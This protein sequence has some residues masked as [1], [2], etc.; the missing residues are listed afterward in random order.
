M[1]KST[2]ILLALCFSSLAFS[3]AFDSGESSYFIENNGQLT[4]LDGQAAD[5]VFFYA[6][7]NGLL[8][9]VKSHGFSYI[10]YQL[11][12]DKEKKDKFGKDISE[13]KSRVIYQAQ[14][15]DVDFGIPGLSNK[16]RLIIKGEHP[17]GERIVGVNTYYLGND[18]EIET[19]SYQKVRIPDVYKGIDVVCEIRDGKFKYS[20]ELNGVYLN[21]PDAIEMTYTGADELALDDEG[22]LVVGTELGSLKE[23][24]PIS[25]GK[26]GEELESTFLL[27][28]NVVRFQLP[29]LDDYQGV[30]IDPVLDWS[31]YAS[32]T[33][34]FSLF[35][36]VVID[37]VR[38]VYAAGRSDGPKYPTTVGAIQDTL[39]GFPMDAIIA[40]YTH[41]GKRR[42]ATYYGGNNIDVAYNLEVDNEQNVVVVGHSTST[43]FRTTTNAYQ[44]TNSGA[45]D[46]FVLKIDSAGKLVSSTLFGGTYDE[47][48]DGIAIDTAGS[49]IISG[50]TFSSDIPVSNGAFQTSTA[51]TS[52]T[53]NDA[54]LA[55]FDKSGKLSWSTYMGGSGIEDR[56][57]CVTVDEAG[58]IYGAGW[59]SST[60]FPVSNGAQQGTYAGNVDGFVFKFTASGGR[61]WATYNGGTDTDWSEDIALDDNDDVYCA[62][63]TYSTNYPVT[64][65][66]IQAFLAGNEDT[67]A[68]KYRSNGRL[69]WSTYVGGTLPDRSYGI[70]ADQTGG[71]Y[72]AGYTISANFPTLRAYQSIKGSQVDGFIYKLNAA[73]GS[74]LYSSLFGGNN[75]DVIYG[76]DMDHQGKLMYA[77]FTYSTNLPTRNA[78]QSSCTVCGNVGGAFVGSLCEELGNNSISGGNS[79]CSAIPISTKLSGSLPYGGNFEYFWETST[80]TTNWLLITK[81][82]GQDYTTPKL[83]DTTYFRRI[84]T[85]ACGADTS[86]V[87][88]LTVSRTPSGGQLKKGTLFNGTYSS[89][90]VDTVCAG[91]TIS[92]AITPPANYSNQEY[93]SKW[94]I[95]VLTTSGNGSISDTS[96]VKPV[97]Q[98]YT[99]LLSANSGFE[100]ELVTITFLVRDV[101]SGCDTTL[102]RQFYVNQ[103]LKADFLAFSACQYQKIPFTD[104][105]STIEG[106][107]TGWQWEFGDGGTSNVQNPDHA[108]S[109]DGTFD[110]KLTAFGDS[111]CPST[112]SKSLTV[113]SAPDAGFDASDF[114]FKDTVKFSDTS[115]FS[116]PVSHSWSFGNGFRSSLQNPTHIYKKEG[117]FDVQLIVSNINC[118]DTA[119]KTITIR[120]TPEA[121]FDIKDICENATPVIKEGSTISSGSIVSYQWDV[122]G[123]LYNVQSP[124]LPSFAMA[125]SYDAELTVES[126][127]GCKDAKS[128]AFS[129]YANP[130]AAFSAVSVCQGEAISLT[131]ESTISQGRITQNRWTLGDGNRSFQ[132]DPV[133]TYAQAGDYTVKLETESDEGCKDSIEKQVQIKALPAATFTRSEVSNLT[134]DFTADESSATSYSWNFGDGET[135]TG[136]SVQHEYATAGTYDVRLTVV[137]DD[138]EGAET[139]ELVVKD[140]HVNTVNGSEVSFYPNPVE[141]TLHIQ[142]PSANENVEI[143]ILDIN[144]RVVLRLNALSGNDGLI[145]LDIQAA[146][147]TNGVF[148][149]QGAS[150]SDMVRAK[151]TKS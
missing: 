94:E 58:N 11:Q 144:G 148:I 33:D 129:V 119:K 149:L 145:T 53:E 29:E 71:V 18:Q 9:A 40:K 62:G 88:I 20:F 117:D 99:L 30:V 102:E 27:H 74:R 141:E 111:T 68:A 54:F 31:T 34:S 85:N 136:K 125:G 42:W 66:A 93:G 113:L 79:L 80:D 55:K 95:E 37:D 126:N 75:T 82:K 6:K 19:R 21:N 35:Y 61:T 134:F 49:V 8:V 96:V 67:Y 5:D 130:K 39:G 128:L 69:V 10:P 106:S 15:I 26:D 110:I 104:V 98:D 46:A 81:A 83:K 17:R 138:C 50:T 28:D 133:Y 143:S 121:D 151:F 135:G 89:S 3:Q 47:F 63:I 86:K 123:T 16:R 92:Y 24:A 142:W 2:L 52:N 60:N 101:L 105:S 38:D 139:T 97:N 41:D 103:S 78:V 44:K 115:A 70:V 45:A 87:E 127:T 122:D 140:A 112:I 14:R 23:L 13:Q 7:F 43:D 116:G 59:T 137:K 73:N 108:Y 120:P 109:K 132:K 124:T 84:L 12:S 65:N 114:C 146:S 91:D 72:F 36:D 57:R 147:L 131:N 150:D 100:T 77:G 25:F 4:S 22:N 32:G 56:I 107:V 1:K 118:S 76:I 64:N 51:S 90:N 48:C